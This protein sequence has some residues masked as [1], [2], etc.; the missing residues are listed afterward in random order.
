MQINA[1][2]IQPID[3]VGRV[4]QGFQQGQQQRREME[5][6][7]AL[8]ALAANPNDPQ[9]VAN[10]TRYNPQLG[11]QLQ[12]KR[13][14]EE[15]AKAEQLTKVFGHAA[16]AAK[17]PEQWD[18][19]A[20]YLAQNGIPGAANVVGKFSPEMRLAYMA[21]AGLDEDKDPAATSLQRNY[22]FMKQV[23][24]SGQ[25]AEQYLRGQAEGQPIVAN[26][27]DGTFT[28]VPRSMLAGQAA[29]QQQGGPQVGAVEDGYRF[30][31]GNPADPNS[32][33]PVNGGPTASQSGPF[34]SAGN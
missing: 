22:E 32:W 11:M 7:K 1:G 12:E 19:I 16:R 10:I 8:Q 29:P 13:A 20:G 5:M 33:E 2:L 27:G 6:D 4:Q 15:A 25:L 26:N 21:Q 17:T 23:D 31:G 28:I 14:A 30:R 34:P 24:P 9:A 3:Y 18:A